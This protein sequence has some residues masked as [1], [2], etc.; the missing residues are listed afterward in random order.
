MEKPNR[1]V[2]TDNNLPLSVPVENK[3]LECSNCKFCDES[4][5]I[6]CKKYF[7]KPDYVIDKTEPCPKFESK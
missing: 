3:D 5:T 7:V 2:Y 4:K 1:F 6:E